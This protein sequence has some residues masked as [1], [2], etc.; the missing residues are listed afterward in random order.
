MNKTLTIPVIL[1]VLAMNQA[2]PVFT[3]VKDQE[4]PKL[5]NPFSASYIR[6]NLAKSKPQMIFNEQILT[7]LKGRIKTDP[8]IGNLYQAIR[9]SAFA[10]LEKPVI[11]RVQTSNAILDISRELLRRVN[12]LGLVYLVEGDKTILDRINQEVLATSRFTDW[13]PPV[14]LDVAEICM[15]ISLALDWTLDDLP[16]S[17][18]K[19]AKKALIEK[20]IYPSWEEYGGNKDNIWWINHYNNWNQVCNGGM[21]AASIA[22]AGDDP[23]LAAKTIRRSLDGLPNV[24][25]SYMPEGIYPES[26]MYWDYGTSYTVLTLSMLE[27]AFGSDFG[28]KSYPGFMQS[29]TYKYMTSNLPSGWYY[30]FADCA[31]KPEVD[32]NIIIA[33][34]AVQ[35]GK[36]MFYD[37]EKF[38]TPAKD[39]RLSYLTGAAMAWL[40]Q[41]KETSGEKPP[42]NWVGK[43]K[44]PIAVFSGEGENSDYYFAAKGGCGAVS[45]GNMD[46][47]SFIFEL[48]GVRWSIDPGIQ[49]YMIGE[50]GFDLWRQCQ[51]CQRWELLTKNNLGH[52]TITVDGKRH[53]VDGYAL[54]KEQRTGKNPAVTF[55][56]SPT[57]KGQLKSAFRKFT[58]DSERSLLIE[59]EIKPDETTKEVTWQL[60]TQA[61]VKIVA[62]GAILKQDGK[63]L[64]LTNISHPGIRFT[65]VSLDPPPHKLDKQIDGLKRIEFRI[66]V[67]LRGKNTNIAI[68]MR[69]NE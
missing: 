24:L 43:G 69:L 55:D 31:D 29:A 33:W 23:E 14:Y 46:A 26:P 5:Q 63:K 68:S 18:I 32:G 50:E 15:A 7:G 40:S 17:T 61:D 52:S 13:N 54:I 49:S 22:I 1:I 28:H 47:G 65:V 53:I 25:S 57:F 36:R 39:I 27:T 45:H 30:N 59:D 62:D 44:T 10:I 56:L 66:P 8:V 48:S 21:I 41:Y 34:F 64:K 2:T 20:G 9:L 37:R 11:K 12:M 6:E 35:T 58:R 4:L 3:Q 19:E 42:A 60:I 38:L 16:E 51:D 67:D